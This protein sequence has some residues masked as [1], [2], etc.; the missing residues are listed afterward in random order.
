MGSDWESKIDSR[1]ANGE[2]NEEQYLY[3]KNRDKNDNV[4]G[5]LIIYCDS[6]LDSYL[7]NYGY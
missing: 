3:L 2:I 4:S 5:D 1:L 7:N 6:Q